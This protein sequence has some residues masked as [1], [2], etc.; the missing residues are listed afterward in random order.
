L[1]SIFFFLHPTRGGLERKSTYARSK[2]FREYFQQDLLVQC[3]ID[4]IYSLP[5][6][7]PL[8][9]PL[10]LLLLEPLDVRLPRQQGIVLFAPL[11]GP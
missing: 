7:V 8:D 2:N 5:G 1:F 6:S 4:F 3:S 9:P 11:S 10:L